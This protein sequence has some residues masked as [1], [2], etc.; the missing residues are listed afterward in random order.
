MKRFLKTRFSPILLVAAIIVMMVYGQGKVYAGGQKEDTLATADTLIA[1]RKYNEAILLL[2]Q[3]IKKNPD[4]FDDAQ[5]RLQRIVKL[6]EEYNAIAGDLLNVLVTDP[7]NDERKLAMI[8]QLESL[9][10]APNRAAREFI[11]KTKETALFTYNRAQ[12]EKIM[13]EGRSLI[14]KGDYVG[15]ARRYS[16]GFSL[17]QEEFYQAGYG[18][19][20]ENNVKQGL[21]TIQQNLGT[22]STLLPELQKRIDTFINLTNAFDYNSDFAPILAAYAELEPL[23]LQFASMRNTASSVGLGFQGQFL[24][25]QSADANLG[26]SS[27]LPFAFRFILGRKTEIQPEGIVGAMDTFWVKG[28][29][30]LET[31]TV[32]KLDTMYTG[33]E[34]AY[35]ANPVALQSPMIEQL[36]QSS[37]FA[38]RLLSVWSSMAVKE[39][40]DQVSVYGK[41]IVKN[42][43]P[44]YL[45]VQGLLENTGIMAS[46]YKAL[47]DL[48]D[49]SGQQNSVFDT[50]Q[51]GRASD[52]NTIAGLAN[53]RSA[54]LDLKNYVTASETVAASRLKS[55]ENYANNALS[56]ETAVER[57]QKS[58]E[59]LA[60]LTQLINKQ[61][62]TL[63][64]QRFIIENAGI[65][66]RLAARDGAFQKAFGL[67]QGVQ[68]T[69]QQGNSYLAKYPKESLPL[70]T[71]LDRLLAADIQK[72]RTVLSAYNAEPVPIRQAEVIQELQQETVSLLTALETLQG[73]TKTNIASAQQQVALAETL[74]LEGDRRF[75]EAQTALKNLNFDLARQ[76]LQQSGERYDAS[77]A[78]QE[79]ADLRTLR[80]QRLLSLAAEISKTENETVVRDVRRLITEAKKSYFNGDFTK[81][82]ETLLQAQSRWKTTNVEDEPEV[83]YWLTLARSALSIKT[84]RTI[85]VT[86]PLYPEMSQLLSAA[87]KAFETGKALL[88]AKKRTEALEQFAIART[89][90][91]EVR[92]LFPLNQDAGLL[93]LQIDQL[94]DP[95]A[96]SANFRQR[97]SDAQ[98]KLAVQPQEGYAELQDLYTINPNYP[99]I[100]TIIEKAEIQLGLRLPPPDPKAIARSNEL[101]AAARR[102]IDANTR[103]QFPVAL[104]QLNEALKLNPN[105]EQAIAL[106][107]RIQTDVGGQATV[108]LSS[109]AEREYQR[110]VQELQNGNTIVALAIVEQLLQDPKNRNSTKLVEL[111]KRIQSRL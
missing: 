73:K 18:E 39:F 60:Y 64:S 111:Q 93:E 5:R 85:P 4:R 101:T 96:F 80:D 59:H 1:E 97:L 7:T 75:L 43:V 70:L 74:R 35:Q 52:D 104:A 20:I 53:L 38:L 87:Q 77:L 10:A 68:I 15:A 25:L 56:I 79:A 37:D 65:N 71:D 11:L 36:R 98:A 102:I 48:L 45:A 58:I 105:N 82:E 51:A 23:L 109:A 50:W 78:V 33:F 6:R 83:A 34:K 27:F 61:E 55:Y 32:Q 21:K 19:I 46:Y 67:L 94:I 72:V 100:K 2:T 107:D 86:A 13:A 95:A 110:A 29:N 49:L 8:R 16:D 30:A 44:V 40:Q 66:N 14:D 17:Y 90:I 69:Q 88:A 103:S 89:K 28:V 22:F 76:R 42:K 26:D 62:L 106:K 63:A 41:S 57:I 3:F 24:L 47:K 31:A 92:I 12:F 81:A 108:V 54:I 91:Q 9:E 99:G 84:G